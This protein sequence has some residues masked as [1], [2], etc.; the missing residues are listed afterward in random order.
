MASMPLRSAIVGF[1]RVAE[2][3]AE[4][5][6]LVRHYR[7]ATHAQVLQEHPA[8]D[9][10]GVCDTDA[11]ALEL[12]RER[13]G[14]THTAAGIAE[15][16]AT[17]AP[18]VVVV[19]AGTA[20][21]R[22][23]IETCRCLK[24]LIVEKPLGPAPGEADAFV[25]LCEVRELPVQ[26]NYWRR[27]DRLFRRLAGG[28]L[29]ERIGPAQA[30]F[31]TYGNGL[32]NN[33]S[34]MVDFLRM[35][36]G[37]VVEARALAPAK[38]LDG[39]PVAGDVAVPFAL[40]F[41]NGLCVSVGALD[42][43]HYREFG[44]DIWGERG[45]LAIYQEGLALYHHPVASNRAMSADREVV[46]EEYERLDCTVG[47]AFYEMYDNILAALDYGAPLFSPVSS[48]GRSEQVVDAIVRSAGADGARMTLQP[49]AASNISE[50][51]R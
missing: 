37:E 29:T 42:F 39:A 30:A 26:V 5:D 34:H 28:E 4:D 40:N 3:Y 10:V 19:T 1:G 31:A 32:Y 46:S 23:V 25:A 8:F 49:L 48:A 33:G 44:L 7:Y 51:S 9:W 47:D 2:G 6:K 14:V 17:V 20:A 43:Q 18:E 13:W 16:E 36:F 15:L 27:A 35:L 38:R 24:G 12:A 22:A 21:A 41:D 50:A 11:A 45:R